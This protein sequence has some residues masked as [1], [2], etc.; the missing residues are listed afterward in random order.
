VDSFDV[1]TQ[2]FERFYAEALAHVPNLL[3]ALAILLVALVARYIVHRTTH[4]VLTRT[5]R[6]KV[7]AARIIETA[8]LVVGTLASLSVLGISLTG[9][10]TGV[11]L[12]TVGLSFA[13]QDLIVNFVAG[14]ELLSNAPFELGDQVEIGEVRGVVRSIG[15]RTTMVE[16]SDGTRITVPNRDLLTKSVAVLRKPRRPHP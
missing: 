3:T 5:T 6:R 9:L 11:G 2:S 14:L 15:T 7:L 4:V 1:L 8:I 12:V 10:L 13:L 16:S